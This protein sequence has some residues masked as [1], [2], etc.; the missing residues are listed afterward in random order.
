M[1]HV[2]ASAVSPVGFLRLDWL[3]R[4][5]CLTPTV[6]LC[7]RSRI[8][9][10]RESAGLPSSMTRWSQIK[11]V[12]VPSTNPSHFTELGTRKKLYT[13]VG[14]F[15]GH[16]KWVHFD[17]QTRLCWNFRLFSLPILCRLHSSLPLCAECCLV[18][19]QHSCLSHIKM[20]RQTF[21]G[22]IMKMCWSPPHMR[23]QLATIFSWTRIVLDSFVQST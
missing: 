16:V 14:I 7:R 15:V 18:F 11:I 20:I 13:R 1:R 23:V 17:G 6:R 2:C 21:G 5:C 22:H 3:A 4:G 19:A 10:F 9:F 12:S 8:W